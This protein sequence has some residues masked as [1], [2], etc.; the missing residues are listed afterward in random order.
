MAAAGLWVE[1][2]REIECTSRYPLDA[3]TG[4]I[5]VSSSCC[6]KGKAN[7]IAK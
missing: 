5:Q 2:L 6:R 1:G 4:F 7:S 3:K